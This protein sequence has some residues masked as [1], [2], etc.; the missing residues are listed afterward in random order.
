METTF[1]GG[2]LNRPATDA[3]AGDG[4]RVV[5]DGGETFLRADA[6]GCRLF[7]WGSL[8]LLI[9]GYVAAGRGGL[10]DAE[11]TA[12]AIRCHYLEHGDLA[13]DGLEGS[14]TVALIDGQARRV[15]LYRNLVGAGFT[16]Y[17]TGPNGFLFGG[18]LAHLVEASEAPRRPNRDVLPLF[19][20]YRFTPGRD[21]LFES[22]HRLLPGEQITWD[23]RGLTRTQ[24]HTFADL[25]ETEA[26]SDAVERLQDVMGSILNDCSAVYPGAAN[27]LSG[28]VDSSY[29]QAIWNRVAPVSDAAPP[30]FSISVDHPRTW[31]DTDYAMT[32]AQA[33]GTAHT[34]IP[35]DGL[36]AGY[37][38]ETLSATGEP[39]NHVQTAYFPGLARAMVGQ[40]APAGLCGEGADS[41]FGVGLA[42]AIHEAEFARRALPSRGLRSAAAALCRTLGMERLAGPLRL[43]N[44]LND[45]SD[46]EHPVNQ[47]ASFADWAAARACFGESAVAAAAAQRRTLL[48]RLAVPT[49]PQDRLHGAGFLGEA[50][51]S[52]SLWTTLFNHAGADLL[53][54]F[55]DSRML[56]FALN[57]PPAVRYPFR[58]PK[59][60][61]KK[62]LERV[63]PREVAR[64]RKLGFGQPIFEWLAPGGQLRPL[65][66]RI[67]AYDFV[68]PETL[69]QARA[70]PNWFLY[71]LLCYDLWHKLFIE[72][73][74]PRSERDVP[75]HRAAAI[76]AP[77]R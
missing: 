30:S 42:S 20:L 77:S 66:E 31:L 4:W 24:R 15:L 65:V 27:L 51:D 25:R 55:L 52:A 26:G 43:A 14:F 23:E 37:L 3:N 62:A 60:L 39:P 19:F 50:V 6:A 49:A 18:N 9:R 29:I 72:R 2:M 22:F 5:G 58:R 61:L 71:S 7:T 68:R 63:V 17:H 36:Y 47:A 73:S 44:A 56:R 53:C 11:T 40:G 74:L 54:P 10:P 1:L 59:E 8:A 28:G 46:L 57:L 34:L 45:F 38:V 76:L 33:L 12:E 35:A 70:G 75:A 41:L 64:R 16:Y 48:D 67:G 13:V 69:E 21:T 32:A